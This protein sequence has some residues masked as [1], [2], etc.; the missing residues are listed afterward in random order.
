MSE[1]I[2]DTYREFDKI[3]CFNYSDE[4]IC[5]MEDVADKAF[6]DLDW[7]IASNLNWNSAEQMSVEDVYNEIYDQ[8]DDEWDF[9]DPPEFLS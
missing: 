6:K 1:S 5:F 7:E 4:E 9:P 8:D 2:F 3:V